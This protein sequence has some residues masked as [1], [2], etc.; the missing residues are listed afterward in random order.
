LFNEGKTHGIP[1]N[2]WDEWISQVD[3]NADGGISLEEFKEMMVSLIS[4]A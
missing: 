1:E 4:K 2:V 3:K